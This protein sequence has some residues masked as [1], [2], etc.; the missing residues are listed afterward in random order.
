MRVKFLMILM[1]LEVTIKNNKVNQKFKYIQKKLF[2]KNIKVIL[3]ECLKLPF[4]CCNN[5][6]TLHNIKNKNNMIM[7]VKSPN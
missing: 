1:T 6:D 7:N 2:I 5:E 3:K 4:Q